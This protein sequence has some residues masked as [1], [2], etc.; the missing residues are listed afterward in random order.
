MQCCYQEA[1]VLTQD[2]PGVAPPPRPVWA[3]PDDC[4]VRLWVCVCACV[5]CACVRVGVYVC[6]SVR[7]RVCACLC[8][9]PFL[10]LCPLLCMGDGVRGGGCVCA[11]ACA[12]FKI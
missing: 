9:R 6:A 11:V 5:V 4:L 3:P 10:C 12:S 1:V 8:L 7:V 2:A